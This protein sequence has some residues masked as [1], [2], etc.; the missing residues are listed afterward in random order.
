MASEDFDATDIR[1]LIEL[2]RLTVLPA[3]SGGP[4]PDVV[5]L[6]DLWR[7]PEPQLLPVPAS[8]R[9]FRLRIDLQGTVPPVWRRVDVPGDILLPRLHGAIQAAM[10]WTDSHLHRFRTANGRNAP[11]F[12]TQ[13]DLD[14]GDEGILEDDVR[15]D[16][17][18]AAMGDR[19]WYDYDFGDGWEHVL[20]VEKVLD[21]PP[22][23]AACI[24]GRR[25]CPPEDCGG[26]S[27]YAE[28]AD[29]VRSGYEDALRPEVFDGSEEGRA[30]LPDGWHPDAFDV[31]ETNV[32]IAAVTAGPVAVVEELA[33]LLELSRSRGA[34]LLRDALAHPATH[35][36]TEISADAAARL[37][38]PFRVLLD[39]IGD[40][41]ALTGAGYLRPAAVEQIAVRT[42]VTDWWIGKANREDL[43]WPVA[44][45]RTAARSLGLVSV[46]KGR[47]APTR[48]VAVHGDDPQA[49]L[50][51][52]VTRL[53]LGKT[54]AERHAG[55]AALAVAGS[56]T[57]PEQ[58]DESISWMMFDLGWRDPADPHRAPSSGSPTLDVLELLAGATHGRW[59]ERGA[60]PGVSAVA[61]AVMRA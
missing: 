13:F 51:H 15:L 54:P 14:E 44:A 60:D 30:W 39:V 20:R 52:I 29:W 61:R 11:E 47:I 21:A 35:G 57:P 16:Q 58:W 6:E 22:P 53:P 36:P 42:G 18:V 48:L 4:V 31:D 45:L 33:S 55:W 19:L 38:Q 50:R 49:I 34:R 7:R 3:K 37:L 27:G 26:T 40:G 17:I 56:G 2:S 24:G 32:L 43:T 46:R 28:L 9:G 25:A 59:R 8:V 23:A 5:G 1:R 41:A 12:L 10:G